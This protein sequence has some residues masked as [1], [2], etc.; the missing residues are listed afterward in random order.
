MIKLSANTTPLCYYLLRTCEEQNNIIFFKEL[1]EHEKLPRHLLRKRRDKPCRES[2][3]LAA[4]IFERSGAR[5]QISES[6]KEHKLMNIHSTKSTKR[7]FTKEGKKI[8]KCGSLTHKNT[9]HRCVC[10][11]VCV[12]VCARARARA[13]T[14]ASVR[15]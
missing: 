3:S 8:C 15:G 2:E 13:F 5:E 1:A 11:C 7:K 12:C 9:L 14:C 6:F 10:V 4:N